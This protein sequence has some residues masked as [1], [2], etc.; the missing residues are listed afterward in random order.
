MFFDET[1]NGFFSVYQESA[2]W[3]L[4]IILYLGHSDKLARTDV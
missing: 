3:E 2:F 4:K 1:K